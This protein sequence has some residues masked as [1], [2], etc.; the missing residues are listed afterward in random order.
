MLSPG[1]I[2]YHQLIL[3]MIAFSV[4]CIFYAIKMIHL[5]RS[6]CNSN[7]I[8]KRLRNTFFSD[9]RS[10]WIGTHVSRSMI[11]LPETAKYRNN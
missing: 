9:Y 5:L 2:R 11:V 10:S 4:V 6:L 1:I 3:F 8:L 7:A